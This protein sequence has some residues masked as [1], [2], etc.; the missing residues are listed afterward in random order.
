MIALGNP[1]RGDDGFGPAVLDALRKTSPTAGDLHRA[2]DDAL[3]LLDLWADRPWVIAIDAADTGATP[4]TH[5]RLDVAD[6]FL[7][8][9]PARV[10]SHGFGLAEAVELG[11]RLGRLPR[12]LIVHSAAGACFAAGAGL[13]PAVAA[14]VPSTAEAV[15][16]DIA[17]LE[18]TAAAAAP[19]A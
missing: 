2:G 15:R 10:S 13:S 9:G 16:R 8:A 3:A 19:D 14:A 18:T 7:P 11:R 5:R 1:A 17:A 12:R 4:G 6:G